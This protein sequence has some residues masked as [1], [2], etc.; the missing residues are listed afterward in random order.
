M[1]AATEAKR[2]K[3]GDYRAANQVEIAAHHIRVEAEHNT[4]RRKW[5]VRLLHLEQSV[6]P[7]N[8][9]NANSKWQDFQC[10]CEPLA[11]W[12]NLIKGQEVSKMGK[13]CEAPRGRCLKA[14]PGS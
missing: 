11:D 2:S 7:I 4:T 9:Q 1:Y 13:M 6:S 14:V 12:W 5:P 10:R 8:T 3:G